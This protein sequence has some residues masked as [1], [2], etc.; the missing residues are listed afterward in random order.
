MPARTG[1]PPHR[2]AL[3]ERTRM[4]LALLQEAAPGPGTSPIA[5][6]APGE[7]LSCRAASTASRAGHTDFRAEWSS[8]DTVPGSFDD[9]ARRV[10]ER[11]Q[12]PAHT[13]QAGDT[14]S[15]RTLIALWD[16]LEK[17]IAAGG[18]RQSEA[19]DLAVEIAERLA[20]CPDTMPDSTLGT[21]IIATFLSARL[22]PP[23]SRPR[24]HSR[25]VDQSSWA[26]SLTPGWGVT[27][28]TRSVQALVRLYASEPWHTAYDREIRASLTSLSRRSR[29][30]LPPDRQ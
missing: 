16:E 4:I 5:A 17:F 2:A 23:A 18:D 22:T 30:D 12:D 1:T 14:A 21:R 19:L 27:A 8:E 28:A 6:Q 29:P 11:L 15:C 20:A 7:H 10:R 24:Q 9:L 25:N 3:E 26:S 13:Q